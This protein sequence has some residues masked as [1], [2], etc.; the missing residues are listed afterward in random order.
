VI[1]EL[2]SAQQDSAENGGAENGEDLAL[3]R[4]A[5]RVLRHADA[6]SRKNA[7]SAEAAPDVTRPS[8][9]PA[10]RAPPR[11]PKAPS[12][13]REQIARLRERLAATTYLRSGGAE[14]KQTA[15]AVRDMVDG[16]R[17]RL[18]ASAHERAE[19]TKTLE[20]A[21]AALVRMEADLQKERRAREALEAQA[22]ERRRIADEA[23]AEAE[24]LAA[25][26]DQVLGELAEQRR[27]EGEQT[28]L[29]EEFEA[30]L[31]QRDAERQS[32]AKE[33]AEV[34]ELV[35]LRSADVDDL[36]SRLRDEAAGRVRAEARCRQLE[37]EIARLADAREALEA[38]EVVL[39]RGR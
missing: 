2:A 27:L 25:E 17:T 3:V 36:E 9:R 39:S 35:L 31:A 13:G 15:A 14:P 11:A 20:E 23:V 26:R 29:L 22:D 8:T 21:R 12:G 33:L 5:L 32:A 7:L 34:R 38:L 28:S 37:A 4:D 19:L 16:L 18:D 24:A 10:H 1:S 30:V 6:E